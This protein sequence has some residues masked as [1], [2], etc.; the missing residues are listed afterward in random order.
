MA[1]KIFKFIFTLFLIYLL[2]YVFIFQNETKETIFNVIELWFTKVVIGILPVYV[3]GSLIMVFPLLS[4]LLFKVLKKLKLFENQKAISLFLISIIV[5]NPTSTI[6][7]SNSYKNKEITLKQ[8]KL[9]YGTC[10]YISPLFLLRI[11]GLKLAST[12]I[13]SQII[14]TVIIY[15]FKA[16]KEKLLITKQKKANNKKIDEVIFEIIDTSPNVLLKILASMLLISIIRIPFNQLSTSN[17]Y[18]FFLDLFEISTGLFD[19]SK[20]TTTN[21]TKLFMINSIVSLNGFAINLQIFYSLKKEKLTFVP[22]IKGRIIN[23]VVST[24]ISLIIFFI[25]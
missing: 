11:L 15:T 2:I 16:N 3:I 13:L 19:I 10:S 12:I 4:F 21:I 25:F 9:I 7:I 18:H 23:L 8:A 22:Y 14:S 17:F 5:G 24:I 1:K 6:L 20:M